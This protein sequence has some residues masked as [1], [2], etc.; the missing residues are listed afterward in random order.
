MSTVLLDEAFP[1]MSFEH[2]NE[3]TAPKVPGTSNLHKELLASG[4]N[5]HFFVLFSSI[6]GIIGQPGQANYV[7]TN[8]LLD[9]LVEN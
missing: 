5:L 1:R 8:C 7:S 2:W 6:S 9:A 3:A 4:T